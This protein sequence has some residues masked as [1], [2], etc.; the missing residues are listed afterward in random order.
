MK[1]FVAGEEN[2]P[3][4]GLLAATDFW[5]DSY[6]H[7]A[8]AHSWGVTEVERFCDEHQSGV[9]DSMLARH[10]G[11]LVAD[12]AEALREL[13]VPSES[14]D[15]KLENLLTYWLS[16]AFYTSVETAI[17]GSQYPASYFP[18]EYFKYFETAVECS[19]LDLFSFE[20]PASKNGLLS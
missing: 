2:S 13:G 12:V 4:Y 3:L 5:H 14:N 20:I 1:Q 9:L 17:T 7:V 16:R 15:L 19:L 11:M 10:T 6:P 18:A 8:S